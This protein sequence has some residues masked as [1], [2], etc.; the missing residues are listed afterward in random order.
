MNNLC[1]STMTVFR[2]QMADFAT[3]PELLPSVLKS[4]RATIHELK[5]IRGTWVGESSVVSVI[6]R[7]RVAS[8]RNCRMDAGATGDQTCGIPG[9]RA[10]SL[11]LRLQPLETAARDDECANVLA[12]VIP[13]FRPAAW[14]EL[15]ARTPMPPVRVTGQL[16]Y[17]EEATSCNTDAAAGRRSKWEI[18]P[19]Y[20]I[21][22]CTDPAGT[23]GPDDTHWQPYDAWVR[24]KGAGWRATGVRERSQCE[25]AAR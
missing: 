22:V 2:M 20:A 1:A 25:S 19:V 3:L 24:N 11:E 6:A 14:S 5:R 15:D 23:C 7:V 16:F 21:D 17:D 4:T 8:L 10:A 9:R 13:H 18:H 12:V